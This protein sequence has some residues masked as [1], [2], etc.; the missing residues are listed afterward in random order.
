MTN[1]QSPQGLP[2]AG[3]LAR[4]T[5][6]EAV[7]DAGPP[8]SGPTVGASDAAADAVRSGAADDSDLAEASR[9]SDGV[10]VGEDDHEADKRNSGA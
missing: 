3:E 5:T 1:S 6:G 10:L 2:V 9:D 8:A 4:E 7:R